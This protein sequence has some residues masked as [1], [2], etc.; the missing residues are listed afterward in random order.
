VRQAQ[1]LKTIKGMTEDQQAEL[2]SLWDENGLP[3]AKSGMND[4][5]LEKA[6]KL[7]AFILN[8]TAA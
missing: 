5:Q 7:L 4:S 1:L 2:S 8:P 3:S 6:E